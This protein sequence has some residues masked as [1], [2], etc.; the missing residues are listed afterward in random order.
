MIQNWWNESRETYFFLEVCPWVAGNLIKLQLHIVP[1]E[2]I[3]LVCHTLLE[4]SLPLL[5]VV[6]ELGFVQARHSSSC[7]WPAERYEVICSSR[8]ATGWKMKELVPASMWNWNVIGF[9]TVRPKDQQAEEGQGRNRTELTGGGV[10][11][12]YNVDPHRR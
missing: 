7:H 5:I 9:G 12:Q 10:T 8:T 11:S 4:M 1:F 2:V 6:L 3:A